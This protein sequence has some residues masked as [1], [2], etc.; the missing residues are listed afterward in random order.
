MWTPWADRRSDF[1]TFVV[2]VWLEFRGASNP[3]AALRAAVDAD[4]QR[5]ERHRRLLNSAGSP[6]LG[7]DDIMAGAWR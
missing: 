4:A 6:D 5:Q 1:L 2:G 3:G 7:D